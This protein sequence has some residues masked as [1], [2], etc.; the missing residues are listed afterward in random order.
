L[1]PSE[2]ERLPI[3]IV[4]VS[5]DDLFKADQAYRAVRNESCFLQENDHRILS[6]LGLS[7]NDMNVLHGAWVRLKNRRQR[8]NSSDSNTETTDGE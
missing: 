7:K 4:N 6:Q 3:P 5:D 2:I 1:V 8:R